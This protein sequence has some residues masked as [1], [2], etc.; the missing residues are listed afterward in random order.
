[1]S[2]I[3]DDRVKAGNVHSV[4]WVLLRND[5]YAGSSTATNTFRIAT[6]EF[7]DGSGRYYYPIIK[8]KPSIRTSID[9]AK[10]TAKTSDVTLTCINEYLPSKYLSE[11]LLYNGSTYYI[12]QVHF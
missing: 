7:S 10:S 1:V 8:N 5:T 12:N 9:L 2:L 11:E 6:S 4:W 3:L